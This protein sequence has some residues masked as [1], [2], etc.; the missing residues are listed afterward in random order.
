MTCPNKYYICIS[1]YT[2]EE[3]GQPTNRLTNRLV[4][5]GSIPT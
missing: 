4:H 1:A 2:K 3:V 5:V